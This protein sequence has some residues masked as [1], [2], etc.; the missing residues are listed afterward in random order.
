MAADDP[1][2][3]EKLSSVGTLLE[4][5]LGT[6]RAL[7]HELRPPLLD[8][9]GWAAA[10]SWLCESFADRTEQ[11]IHYQHSGSDARL[12]PEI[13]LAV[14]RIVQEALTN[15]LRHAAV[16]EAIGGCASGR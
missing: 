2:A 9:V 8:E 12:T 1:A 7:S 6:V 10:L 5:T 15:V 16:N 13:E 4:D 3:P 11:T 14:Y